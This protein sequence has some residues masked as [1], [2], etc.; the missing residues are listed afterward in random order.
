MKCLLDA[1]IPHI[2]TLWYHA[3]QTTKKY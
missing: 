1:S 2:L 3:K